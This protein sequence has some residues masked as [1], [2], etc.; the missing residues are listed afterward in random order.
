M[1][2]DVILET[3]GLTKEFRGFFAVK[4]VDLRVRRGTIHALIGPRP[5]ASTC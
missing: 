2:G 5:P 4:G 3:Q 1:A